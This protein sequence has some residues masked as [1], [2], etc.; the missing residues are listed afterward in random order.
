VL[1][2]R[3]YEAAQFLVLATRDGLI[4]KT[5][6]TEYDTNRSG[7]IIAINLREG[8][9]LVSAL[10]VDET[11]DLLLVSRKGMSVRF[12]ATNDA[13]RPMGRSTSGVKGMTFR[14][15][16]T[17]LSASVVGEDGYVFVVTEGGYAKRTSA[18]QYRVQNRGGMGI[19]VAKLAEA[20]GDLAGALIVSEDDEVLVVLASGKVVRSAVA[21][22][23]AKGRDT[24]GVVFARFADND[25]IIALARN[26]ERHVEEELVDAVTPVD[27]AGKDESVDE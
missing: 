17:L 16:D 22:V 5:A 2:I 4:K 9:E 27:E 21:E 11:D 23:P 12:T 24:M 15:D 7:G 25:R 13:L 18:D 26:A 3:D 19:K 8:D 14:G 20:R 6:L 10:L 1:D